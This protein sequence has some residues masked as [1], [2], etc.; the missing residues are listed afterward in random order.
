[1]L[2][3][4]VADYLSIV[5]HDVP[6]ELVSPQC[7]ADIK[8]LASLLPGTLTRMLGFESRLGGESPRTDFLLCVQPTG[9]EGEVLAGRASGPGF[10]SAFWEHPVW[11]Q[12]RDFCAACVDPSSVLHGKLTDLWLEFD[13]EGPPSTTPVPSVFF[14]S[15]DIRPNLQAGNRSHRWITREALPLV[16]G[17]R[18]PESIE[19][20]LLDCIQRLPPKAMVFDLAAMLGREPAFVRVCIRKL[21]P[22]QIV[23]YLVE[24]GWSGNASSLTTA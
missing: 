16:T 1:M 23:P 3:F 14:G 8:A 15:K 20:T 4:S 21:S 10:S 12:L 18:V 11:R 7:L 24:I 5:E 17:C 19:R 22:S 6:A 2:A 9:R 13:T